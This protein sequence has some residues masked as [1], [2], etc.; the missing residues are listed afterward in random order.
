MHKKIN[1]KYGSIIWPKPILIPH[2]YH[3]VFFPQFSTPYIVSSTMTVQNRP[4]VIIV[5]AGLG[6]ITLGLLLEIAGVN[7]AIFERSAIVRP[8]GKFT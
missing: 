1:F 2:T 7:Y 6:G 3:S 5:G 4:N 8:L